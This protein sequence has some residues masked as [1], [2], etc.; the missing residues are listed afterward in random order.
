MVTDYRG[1]GQCVLNCIVP[2]GLGGGRPATEEFDVAGWTLDRRSREVRDS[3]RLGSRPIAQVGEHLA[4]D[5]RIAHHATLANLVFACFELRL[6]QGK[7]GRLGLEQ[8]EDWWQGKP[9]RD[10]RHVYHR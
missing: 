10:E 2:S 5:R 9:Q 4:M 8:P 3:P 7:Y 1:L 6:D